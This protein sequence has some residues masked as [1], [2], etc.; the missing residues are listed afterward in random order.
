MNPAPSK[1]S[2]YYKYLLKNRKN[3]NIATGL[4]KTESEEGAG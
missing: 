4:N 3:R 2:I 1:H